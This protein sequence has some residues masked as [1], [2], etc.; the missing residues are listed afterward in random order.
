MMG[1]VLRLSCQQYSAIYCIIS[2]K[3]LYWQ[4]K[5]HKYDIIVSTV[6]F[7][8][9]C[10]HNSN[11]ENCPHCLLL[12][13]KKLECEFVNHSLSVVGGRTHTTVAVRRFLRDLMMVAESSTATN[14]FIKRTCNTLCEPHDSSFIGCLFDGSSYFWSSSLFCLLYY[15]YH[16]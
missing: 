16:Q 8:T 13:C 15:R 11:K 2:A 5:I 6:R 12:A 10:M 1:D 3:L 7:R 14:I 9:L 4:Y